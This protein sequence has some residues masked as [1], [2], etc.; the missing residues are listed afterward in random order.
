MARSDKVQFRREF[1]LTSNGYAG[2]SEGFFV[3]DILSLH[4]DILGDKNTFILEGRVGLAN[5]WTTIVAKASDDSF[6]HYQDI[7]IRAFEYIRL[8]LFGVSDTPVRTILFGYEHNAI[9]TEINT[10]ASDRDFNISLN[11]SCTLSDIK[12]ELVKLNQYM[13]II[14]GDK[15]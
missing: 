4:I 2:T 12:E 7:D 3:G 10:K 13:E 6:R 8:E 1:T 9:Q 14:T 5:E 11:D 15:L